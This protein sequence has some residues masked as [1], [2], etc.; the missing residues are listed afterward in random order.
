MKRLVLGLVMLVGCGGGQIDSYIGAAC[1]RDAECD[2]RCYL[3]SRD[4]P[5]GFCSI[6]CESDRD[7]PSDTVCID[8]DGGVC[9]FLCSELDCSRLGRGWGCHDEDRRSG[10]RDSVCIGD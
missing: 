5:G 1:S 4:Y 8:K 9:L 10:G 3:D 7:C 6:S 2:E